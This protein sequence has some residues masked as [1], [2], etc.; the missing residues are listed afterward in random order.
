MTAPE[1]I[2]ALAR[3]PRLL[4]LAVFFLS[5]AVALAYEVAWSRSLLLVL[6]ST[7]TASA[8]VLGTFVGA[9]GLGARWGGRRV[10]RHPRPLLL[11]GVFEIGAAIWAALAPHVADL[12][13][14]PYMAVAAGAPGPVQMLLRLVVAAV[15][16]APA[17]FLLG[18]TLPAMVRHWVRRTDETGRLTAWLYGANTVGAFAGCLFTGYVGVAWLGVHGIV[19]AAAGLGVLVGVVAVLAALRGEPVGRPR[20]L[21]RDIEGG[22]PVTRAL[23]ARVALLCGFVGL[24]TEVVGFRV[25]VFFLEGFTVTFASMLGIFIAGLGLGSLLLGPP[26]ARTRRP[27]RVLGVLLL[28][29]AGALLFGLLVVV[30][31]L[32]VWMKSI[33]GMA[34][35][36]AGS[37]ADIAAGLRIASLMG[38]GLL[39]LVPAILMGPTFPLCVRWAELGGDEPGEAV[40]RVYLFNS[41]GSLAAPFVVTFLA[42]PLF[43]VPGAW[44]LVIALAAASGANLLLYHRWR[45]IKKASIH[46]AALAGCAAA[47]GVLLLEPV[48]LRPADLVGS[49]VVLRGTPGRELVRVASDAVTTASVIETAEGE[50]YLYTDDFAAAATGRHYRYMRMLGHLPCLLAKEPKNAMVIAFGT[51]TTAGAVA[52]HEEVERLEV[53]EVSAAVLDLAPHFAAAN[54]SVLDD[55]RVVQIADDGRNALLLHEPDLDVITLEPLMPY[56][57]HGYPFYTREFYELARARLTDGGVLCQWVPVHAMPPGLYAAFVGT[58]FEVFPEGSLWFFEQSTALIGRKGDAAPSSE[59][60]L[61][62]ALGVAGDL[63]EAGFGRPGLFTAS[64]VA[65]GRGVLASPPPPGAARYRSGPLTDAHPYAEFEPTPRAPLNTPYL[66]QTLKWLTSLARAEGEPLGD[67]ARP[68]EEV[69]GAAWLALAARWKEAEADYVSVSLR[70][71]PA[72]ADARAELEAARLQSLEDAV[73]AYDKAVRI[74]PE[75]HVWRWR[76]V[77]AVRKLAAMRA[78]V[79][80]AR[81]KALDGPAARRDALH[82]ALDLTGAV[83]PP[84]LPDPD[85]VATG[86]VE[87]AALHAAVLLRLGRCVEAADALEAAREAVGD[88]RRARLLGDL[89]DAVAAHA[90]GRSVEVAREGA[91]VLEGR[92]PCREEGLAAVAAQWER[93]ERAYGTAPIDRQRAAARAL[94]VAARREGVAAAVLAI[95]LPEA[96]I[97]SQALHACLVAALGGTD[98]WV[99]E[100]LVDEDTE[101]RRAM[102]LEA[103]WWRQLREHPDALDEA[104]DDPDPTIRKALATGAAE[105]GHIEVLRRVAPLLMDPEVDVR[106]EAFTV[107]LRHR[108]DAVEGYDPRGPETERRTAT[109]AVVRALGP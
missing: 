26:L 56:S 70:G 53:V 21:G 85:P 7:A 55:P 99:A 78:R 17:A 104:R 71:V 75:Q 97:A 18:A 61:R 24:A 73:T 38:A 51:G 13:Q 100:G 94:D 12:L 103:G 15:V 63:E 64:R 43:H 27:A 89:L 83:L 58:F 1:P 35:A 30:P 52:R 82:L 6:G 93:F 9:L 40:G 68:S 79:L 45:A 3:A 23:T 90:E 37:P 77:R 32:E 65:D 19:L 44:F 69:H 102:L 96:P 86:R 10:E 31:S 57:P 81:A 84:V 4:L 92:A 74:V 46:V 107:F 87:A 72:G 60:V 108:P 67:V 62:R 5:G 66:H 34:Y 41:L 50:R 11:Y 8:V 76:L 25:L 42:I 49:S 54:R 105:H 88:L 33:R 59:T 20:V 39:L 109:E 2:R 22:G 36:G 101:M 47:L 16:V 29:Q 28:L 48:G 91:W 80:L 95:E 98:R 106:A 14:G